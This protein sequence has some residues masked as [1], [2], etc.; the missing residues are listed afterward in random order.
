M[1]KEE[2]ELIKKYKE[3]KKDNEILPFLL[4][5]WYQCNAKSAYDWVLIK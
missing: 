2:L 1:L 3:Q 5:G 4:F